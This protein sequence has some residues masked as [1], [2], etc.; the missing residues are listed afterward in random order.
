MKRGD[1]VIGILVLLLVTGVAWML[2]QP[3]PSTPKQPS[4]KVRTATPAPAT[5]P[6]ATQI[7]GT[8]AKSIPADIRQQPGGPYQP[9]DPRWAERRRLLKEDPQYEWKTP[10]EFYGKV[11]DEDGNPVAGATADISWT[12]MSPNGSSNTQVTSDGA[13][14]F[15]ITRVS[16]KHMTVQVTKH[17]YYRETSKGRSSYE[18]AGFWEPTYHEPNSSSPIIFY[19][20][21]KGISEPLILRGPILLGAPNDGRPINIDLT[22]GRKTS[23]GSGNIVLRISKGPKTNKRFDWTAIIEGVDGA[24]LIES[25]DDLWQRHQRTATNRA[26]RS[27]KRQPMRNINPR[28]RPSST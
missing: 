18:Y 13:G 25:K 2:G 20:R 8:D 9:A 16:G 6:Q 14:L 24:G 3:K 26:G 10:I 22:T 1:I 11:L 28:C 23:D 21:K 27:V 5:S 15:S 19:L 7:R 17:G 12:D 4:A